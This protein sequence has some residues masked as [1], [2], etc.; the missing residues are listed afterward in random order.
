VPSL[1]ASACRFLND[2]E[3]GWKT[4]AGEGGRRKGLEPLP[5]HGRQDLPN[6]KNGVLLMG[7]SL[8]PKFAELLGV[9]LKE[10]FKVANAEGKIYN[11][12]YMID[13]NAL[14]ER[15]NG[16]TMWFVDYHTLRT[17]LNGTEKLVRLPENERKYVK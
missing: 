1:P 15:K 4:I 5:T 6:F 16:D 12:D 8:M 9:G 17:L 7:E 13:T 11:I 14:W 3:S 2:C 10:I